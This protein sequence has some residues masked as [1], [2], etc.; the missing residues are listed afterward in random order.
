MRAPVAVAAEVPELVV[1]T[2][3]PAFLFVGAKYAIAA[4]VWLAA[5]AIVAV[6]ASMTSLPPLA[7]AAIVALVGL[8][9]FIKPVL[10][11]IRRQRRLYTLTNHK[12][13]IREG[14]LS[15]TVRNV[16][17]SKVQD[18]T[19]TA[20]FLDR[21]LGLGD[22]RIDNA[23]EKEGQIVIKGVH[24]PKRFADMLLTE[25]RRWN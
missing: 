7:G 25:L 17:L 21:L 18:V 15:Q 12:L 10:A 24:G 20:S 5:T 4:V 3:R 23:S 22:I 6:V 1:F 11:H 8:L 2:L 13:E 19:V 14:I 16:P 9:V